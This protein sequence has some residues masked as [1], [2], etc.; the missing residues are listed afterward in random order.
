M[1]HGSSGM[2][3]AQFIL[4]YNQPGVANDYHRLS[5]YSSVYRI[6][7]LAFNLE[8]EKVGLASNLSALMIVLSGTLAATLIAYPWK[9]L[10]W[11]AQLLKK[12]F[13][14]GNEIDWTKNTIVALA[15]NYRKK[16]NSYS[17]KRWARS[18]PMAI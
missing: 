8:W 14:S 10:I 1:I 13:L 11:T 9:R 2:F 7:F 15:R 4:K 6:F 5:F 17:G 18:C 12:A 16:R 3:R